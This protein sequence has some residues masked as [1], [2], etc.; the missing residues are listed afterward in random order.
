MPLSELFDCTFI[1][2]LPQRADRRRAVTKELRK[3]G[4][5]LAGGAVE[6]FPAIRPK[7]SAGFPSPGV[8]G[9]FLSHLAILKEARRRGLASI[10]ILEDDLVISPLVIASFE[11]IRELVQQTWWDIIY[12]GHC[13][14][15]PANGALALVSFDGPI[16]TS[17]FYAINE[18]ALSCLVDYLEYAQLREPGDPQGGPMHLDAAL[19]MF[20]LANPDLVTL[21]SAPNLGWQRPSSS[22]IHSNWFQQ[23]PL[24]RNAYD[25]ARGVR[26]LFAGR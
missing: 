6:L 24:F 2:N 13:E 3:A 1:V 17:H 14:E 26:S 7:E 18:P 8:R 4:I 25:I 20:R 11:R 15:P 22:D 19:T 9:C 5:E 23:A 12:F 16:R 10:L 21:I